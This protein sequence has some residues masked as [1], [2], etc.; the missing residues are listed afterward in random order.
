MTMS[1]SKPLI[2]ITP[3]K[4]KVLID[5]VYATSANFTG[6]QVYRTARCLLHRDAEQRLRKAVDI[7]AL[8]GFR[9]KVLDA[10][11]PPEA[12][13]IFWKH[14]PDP[15][16]VADIVQGSNHSRGV[17]I[18]L[19]LVDVIEPC[20]ATRAGVLLGGWPAAQA[21]LARLDPEDPHRALRL[22]AYWGGVELAN[23]FAELQDPVLQRRRFQAANAVRQAHDLPVLPLPD[24]FLASLPNLPPC[25]GMALGLDRLVMLATGA[26]DIGDV[27]AYDPFSPQPRGPR[28]NP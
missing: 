15:R 27:L 22:E 5:L 4:H 25:A 19:T 23:G 3:R 18:D 14:L 20:L 1:P 28:R 7:A 10:Y 8:A 11:R 26:A 17:A 9:L 2:E 21:S 13:E 6:R 24:R 12:Q 16:Y